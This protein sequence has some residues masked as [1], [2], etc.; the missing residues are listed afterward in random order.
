MRKSKLTRS[1]KE[2]LSVIGCIT[3]AIAVAAAVAFWL[4]YL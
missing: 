3:V 1:D 2:A 4:G